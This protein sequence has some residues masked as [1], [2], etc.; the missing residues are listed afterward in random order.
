MRKKIL[1]VVLFVALVMPS[2]VFAAGN[3]GNPEHPI[4]TCGSVTN[5]KLTITKQGS[6]YGYGHALRIEEATGG[7]CANT[8]DEYVADYTITDETTCNSTTNRAWYHYS[9]IYVDDST[10]PVDLAS[11]TYTDSKLSESWNEGQFSYNQVYDADLTG[12]LATNTTNGFNLL[13]SAIVGGS[14]NEALTLATSGTTKVTMNG[15]VVYSL[16]GGNAAY[17]TGTTEYDANLTGSTEVNYNG[18]VVIDKVIGGSY[19]TYSSYTGSTYATANISGNVVLNHKADFSVPVYA[20]SYIADNHGTSTISGTKT[21]TISGDATLNATTL[22]NAADVLN[23]NKNADVT[24]GNQFP[25]TTINVKDGG[26]LTVSSTATVPSTTT[27]NA[28]VGGKI[29][30]DVATNITVNINSGT[31]TISDD[32]SLITL[33]DS[34]STVNVTGVMSIG[35]NTALTNTVLSSG[36]TYDAMK[37]LMATDETLIKMFDLSLPDG[38]DPVSNGTLIVNISLGSTY[39][40]KTVT[41]RHLA[42]GATT[43]D[44]Y[45]VTASATGVATVS[46]TSLSPISVSI[47]ASDNPQTSDPIMTSVILAGVSL[48]AIAGIAIYLNK[49]KQYN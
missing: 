14:K 20:G 27:F 36:D 4:T 42:T 44:E 26:E 15:G 25:A 32:T 45:V 24:I 18:G 19:L 8:A 28:E 33:A 17:A 13:D 12:I 22:M 3:P 30:S 37:E 46:L 16:I 47:A 41:I 21:L 31:M 11:A 5:C 2:F 35:S 38:A 7:F 23:I 49:K 39:A 29:N 6:I 43:A 48:I 40:N 34:G 10:T 1:A 9:L